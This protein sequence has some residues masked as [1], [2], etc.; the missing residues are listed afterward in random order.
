MLGK[1]LCGPEFNLRLE[2][3]GYSMSPSVVVSKENNTGRQET[4]K[5]PPPLVP[6][7]PYYYSY[8]SSSQSFSSG[9]TGSKTSGTSGL[10]SNSTSTRSTTRVSTTRQQTKLTDPAKKGVL[11]TSP[12][13]SS[14]PTSDNS[15]CYSLYVTLKNI[16]GSVIGNLVTPLV[17]GKILYTPK[18]NFTTAF[19]KELNTTFKQF[20]QLNT[21]LKS[22]AH[23]LDQFDDLKNLTSNLS[24][25]LNL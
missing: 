24:V 13:L 12:T 10:Y 14:T 17:F 9:S 22:F 25:S 8:I 18:N 15:F 3:Y 11:P 21:L 19:V 5:S 4:S 7:S 16:G 1:S 6:T 2:D 23:G 20:Y